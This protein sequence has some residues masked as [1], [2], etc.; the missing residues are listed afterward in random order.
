METLDAFK[1]RVQAKPFTSA[2]DVSKYVTQRMVGRGFTRMGVAGAAA[3]LADYGRGIS[4]DKIIRLAATAEAHGFTEL[5]IGFWDVAYM[6]EH[7][8]P[9]PDIRP[10]VTPPVTAKPAELLPCEPPEA[11]APAPAAG[12]QFLPD[13]LQPGRTQAMQPTDALHKRQHYIDSD[14]YCGQPKKDGWTIVVF[15][16]PDQTAY[17]NRCGSGGGG[18]VREAPSPEIDRALRWAAAEFGS[19]VL[20][21]ELVHYS[22][23]GTEHRSAPQAATVNLQDGHGEDP[24]HPCIC[25]FDGLW[26]DNCDLRQFDFD[27]RAVWIGSLAR[28]LEVEFPGWFEWLRPIYGRIEKAKL[29]A[30]QQDEHREGEI[31]RLRTAPFAKG[32]TSPGRA[33]YEPIVRTKYYVDR[34]VR[35]TALAPTSATKVVRLFSALVVA[36]PETGKPLGSVG[37]GFTTDDQVKLKWAFEAARSNGHPLLVEVTAPGLTEGGQLWLPVF[38]KIVEGV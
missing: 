14:D 30:R 31:W 5:A 36:D 1:S 2:A 21:G 16:T 4:V 17:Q 19:F 8:Q 10:A 9:A 12:W 22:W 18:T 32:K 29:A 33:R 15:A 27:G 26:A 34:V 20:V 38:K 11:L 28:E 24:V 13:D 25:I 35:V 3:Y 23:Q 7:G 6:T 37:T